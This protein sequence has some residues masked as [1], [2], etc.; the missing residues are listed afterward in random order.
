MIRLFKSVGLFGTM[1]VLAAH[2]GAA[3]NSEPV[4]PEFWTAEPAPALLASAE[5]KGVAT[6]GFVMPATDREGLAPGDAVTAL[7]EHVDGSRRRQWLV[8]LVGTMPEAA[9]TAAAPS[10]EFYLYSSTGNKHT[11]RGSRETLALQVFGPVAVGPDATKRAGKDKVAHVSARATVS[12]D[13]LSLGLARSCATWVRLRDARRG[14]GEPGAGNVGLNGGG[15]PFPA[16]VVATGQ[17]LARSIGLTPEDERALFGAV[18]A[19]LEFV[20]VAARTPGLSDILVSVVDI[21]VW[22][23]LTRGGRMPGIGFVHLPMTAPLDVA[24]WGVSGASGAHE[25]GFLMQLNDRP[26]LVLRLAVLEPRPPF[27]ASAG[28][29]GLAA[30]RPDGRGPRL[31]IRLIASRAGVPAAGASAP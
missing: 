22:S 5:A 31:M 12:G 29:L 24:P 10:V 11:F 9:E 23:I 15:Q 20:N 26:S 1:A 3:A 16:D 28:V 6:Q 14:A 13:F 8:A 18:P 17:A 30:C 19:L 21:P 7:V 27:G 25:C 4:L 2:H